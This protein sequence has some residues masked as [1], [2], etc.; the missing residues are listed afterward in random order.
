MVNNKSVR[1][2]AINGHSALMTQDALAGSVRDDRPD[3]SARQLAILL[4][5]A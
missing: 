4:T 5:I 3:L 1:E 2:S